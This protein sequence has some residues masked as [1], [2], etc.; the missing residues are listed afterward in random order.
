M[1]LLC[2]SIEFL[3]YEYRD[4]ILGIKNKEEI[5]NICSKKYNRPFDVGASG[6]LSVCKYPKEYKIKYGKGFT[7]KP[8][9]VP[10]NMHLKVGNDNE[11]LLR[12]YF[13]FDKVKKLIVVG[14][15]PKHL[16]TILYK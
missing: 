13:L 1:E 11:N 2:D 12:I 10:L 15:L 9:E 16:P 8:V 6:D 14:S 3:A 4:Q 7:G 5:N